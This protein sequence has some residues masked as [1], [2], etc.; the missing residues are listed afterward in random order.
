[1]VVLSESKLKKI[2]ETRKLNAEQKLSNHKGRKFL[3]WVAI[4]VIVLAATSTLVLF[5]HSSKKTPVTQSS[6]LTS[7]AGFHI[8]FPSNPTVNQSSEVIDGKNVPFSTYTVGDSNYY[9][10]VR[11][12]NFTNA[13]AFKYYD[14]QEKLAFYKNWIQTITK[15]TLNW[16][17]VS[18]SQTMIAGQETLQSTITATNDNGKQLNIYFYTLVKGE[19]LYNIFT[20]SVSKFDSN[21]FVN[22]FSIKN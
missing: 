5:K 14:D 13:I 20:S 21:I 1:L 9:Y 4:I 3:T 15:S 17:I 7:S 8:N 11:K 12:Y 18:S 10:I 2:Q 19:S 6:N 16:S 22:S